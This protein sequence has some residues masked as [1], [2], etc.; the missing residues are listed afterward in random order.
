MK[1]RIT[2]PVFFNG[3][4]RKIGDVLDVQVGPFRTEVVPGGLRRIPQFVE[5]AEEIKQNAA[6]ETSTQ[7]TTAPSPAANEPE[8]NR[9]VAA[10]VAGSGGPQVGTFGEATAAILKPAAP[11]AP[12]GPSL[13]ARVRAL[14]A[15]RAKSHDHLSGMLDIGET[16]MSQVETD[17]PKILQRVVDAAH[18][19]ISAIADLA[20]A[21]KEM[22]NGP[23]SGS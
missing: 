13:A 8:A 6:A 10:P 20:D 17:G 11:P 5:M 16:A 18:D 2:E 7:S 9:G 22:G 1:I 19:D 21:L 23:L 3:E 15:R 4:Q 14:T 12:K